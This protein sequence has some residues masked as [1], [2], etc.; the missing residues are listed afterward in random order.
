MTVSA[1]PL[2]RRLV[3]STW[4]IAAASLPLGAAL[5]IVTALLPGPPDL[6]ER[7]TLLTRIATGLAISTL[8]LGVIALLIRAVDR[9]PLAAVGLNSIRTGW[10]IAGWGALA[11]LLPAAASFGVLALLGAPLSTTVSAGE[12]ARTTLLLAVAVLLSEALPEEV[13]FRGYI[14]R[15]LG[16]IS[17]GWGTI[18]I[19]AVIFTLFAGALRQNWDPTDLSLF[20][21]MGI[22]FGYLRLIT[23]SV[24]MSIGFHTAFQTGAQLV[25]SHDA[26]DFAGGIGAAMLALGIIPF[27]VAAILASTM[28]SS[29]RRAKAPKAP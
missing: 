12:L 14:A 18:I 24:W 15:A 20:L 16:A 27:T 1:P 13:L 8:T 10:R 9:L 17:S 6:S 26:V 11:W 19:Q 28:G 3:A 22:V 25:L 23:G 4:R 2:P 7:A 21:T 5:A 29:E